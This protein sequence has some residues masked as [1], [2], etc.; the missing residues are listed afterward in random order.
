MALKA[1]CPMKCK[2]MKK[3]CKNNQ[4]LKDLDLAPMVKD[5][6]N[7]KAPNVSKNDKPKTT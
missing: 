1:K 4:K 2:R 6:P 5:L 3:K 7:K